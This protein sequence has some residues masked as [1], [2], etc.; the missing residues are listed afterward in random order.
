MSLERKKRQ[1]YSG[2]ENVR[3]KEEQQF[4]ADR[5]Q[6]IAD[7]RNEEYRA[8][9]DFDPVRLVSGFDVMLEAAAID[10]ALYDKW[11]SAEHAESDENLSS[12]FNELRVYRDSPE[13]RPKDFKLIGL[14]LGAGMASAYGPGQDMALED[15]GYAKLFDVVIGSSG[16]SGPPLFRAS[17]E[18]RKGASIFM[19]EATTKEFIQYKMRGLVPVLDTRIISGVM[20]EGPKAVDLDALR[21]SN[22]EVWGIVT[23]KKT[24]KAELKNM[25]TAP[26]PMIICEASSAIPGMKIPSMKIE[27]VE[28]VDGAFA[29]LPLEEII[30]KFKPSHI[31][32][33]PNRAFD[34][35]KKFHESEMHEDI[36]EKGTSMLG[37][38]V[39]HAYSLSQV[40]KMKKRVGTLLDKIGAEHNVK[41]AVLWP[42]EEQLDVF[43]QDPDTVR[44][45]ILEAYRKTISDIGEQ[46]PERIEFMPGDNLPQVREI[47]D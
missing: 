45:G 31:L 33:Q 34:F 5:W 41:I 1:R 20:R 4:H 43:T 18:S 22:T 8:S 13:K 35:L 23:N 24:G 10:D 40:Y 37:S 7:A 16:A 36:M 2:F 26:D 47:R 17:G 15:T 25:S 42:P 19:N 21:K 32:A 29:D 12:M 11:T 9:D 38:L 28:Y 3:P 14:C 46:Q 6:R 44:T 27:G 30:T 39:P